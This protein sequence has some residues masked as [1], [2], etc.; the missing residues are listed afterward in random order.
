MQGITHLEQPLISSGDEKIAEVRI[1]IK[2]ES[3]PPRRRISLRILNSYAVILEAPFALF[4]GD[5][6]TQSVTDV[7]TDVHRSTVD[8]KAFK[9]SNYTVAA[10]LSI[11]DLIR[12]ILWVNP[13]EDTEAM[14]K[15]KR[16]QYGWGTCAMQW[17]ARATYVVGALP[18]LIAITE[19]FPNTKTV[20]ITLSV[21][22]IPFVIAPGVSYFE[23]LTSKK[24]VE[25]CKKLPQLPRA[26][27]VELTKDPL[28]TLETA[29]VVST[30]A[31]MRGITVAGILSEWS[32][33]VFS[34]PALPVLEPITIGTTGLVTLF[35]RSL[36]TIN[37]YHNP[38]Y[39]LLTPA[40]RVQVQL[41]LWQ[42]ISDRVMALLRAGPIGALLFNRYGTESGLASALIGAATYFLFEQ[43]Y[44]VRNK[45]RINQT[46][47]TEKKA[48][49]ELTPEESNKTEA[50]QLFDEITQRYEG[51][52]LDRIVS[53]INLVAS[54][55]RLA[56]SYELGEQVLSAIGVVATVLEKICATILVA[57]PPLE[58]DANFAR[59]E[60]KAN[61]KY[62]LTKIYMH[63]QQS[64]D[65]GR[66]TFWRLKKEYPIEYLEQFL[67]RPLNQITVENPPQAQTAAIPAI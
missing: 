54:I 19:L 49:G 12:S 15:E 35:S 57:V 23:M 1:D 61:L 27:L 46:A 59:E 11:G 52:W 66:Y 58:G 55:G 64:L 26:F 9:I 28:T 10:T 47:L 3:T 25:H 22:G 18:E 50:E 32:K 24:I 6:I 5:D 4:M 51:P 17:V 20:K 48:R 65:D 13:P 60:M 41:S 44:N 40:D 56:L 39:D 8:T 37:Y 30:L 45:A 31:M 14:L 67:P 43:N 38:D 42:K 34:I 16:E 29:F 62:W 7:V 36:S 33:K 63:R 21:L 53:L 2:E